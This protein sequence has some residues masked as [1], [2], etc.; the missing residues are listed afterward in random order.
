MTRKQM[1]TAM[2]HLYGFEHEAVIEFAR[3]IEN[4][5]IDDKTLQTLVMVHQ[6]C[7]LIDD[8]EETVK[9]K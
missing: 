7:P 8:D 9:E 4:P 6:E 1:L 5:N 2:I 3:L